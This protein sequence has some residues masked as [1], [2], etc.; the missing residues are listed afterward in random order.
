MLWYTFATGFKGGGWQFATYFQELVQQGFDPEE[1]E[2]HE[3][4]YKGSFLNDSLSL[5]AVAHIRLD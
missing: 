4:G 2:M 3:I 1:L 5:S